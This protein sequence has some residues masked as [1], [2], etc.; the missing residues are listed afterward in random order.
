M[1]ITSSLR[2]SDT[3]LNRLLSAEFLN[4]YFFLNFFELKENFKGFWKK[5]NSCE[6]LRKCSKRSPLPF[7]S[8]LGKD[9]DKPG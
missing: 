9:L 6:R 8:S 3:K 2:K 1:I 7:A 4:M 5:A